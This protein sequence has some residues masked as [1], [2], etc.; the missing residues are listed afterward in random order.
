MFLEFNSLISNDYIIIF[1]SYFFEILTQLIKVR[2]LITTENLRITL[3]QQ[4]PTLKHQDK[5]RVDNGVKSVSNCHH[6]R[7]CESFFHHLHLVLLRDHV[8][9]RCS[10]VHDD[11][12][13]SSQY[14]TANAN[15]LFFSCG[16]ISSVLFNFVL[17]PVLIL[18]LLVKKIF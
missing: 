14:S 4:L 2:I 16:K 9:V 5:V 7:I 3:L 6:C 11:N 1:Y 12:P 15:E 18:T 10:L 13:C 8:D 17:Q